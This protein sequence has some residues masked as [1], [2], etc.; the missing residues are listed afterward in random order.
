MALHYA[1]TY[2]SMETPSIADSTSQLTHISKTGPSTLAFAT[3]NGAT[4]KFWHVSPLRKQQQALP[5]G[6]VAIS[7]LSP[8]TPTFREAKEHWKFPQPT[9]QF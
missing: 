9:A 2:P 7:H 8:T 4:L 6:L 1:P 3:Q 5:Q